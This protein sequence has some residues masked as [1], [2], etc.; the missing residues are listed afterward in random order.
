MSIER[1][2]RLNVSYN[3]GS[4]FHRDGI[5]YDH[6]HFWNFMEDGCGITRYILEVERVA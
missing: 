6:E 2:R 5:M 1:G 4:T 3:E